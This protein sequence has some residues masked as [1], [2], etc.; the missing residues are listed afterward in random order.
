[1]TST[2]QKGKLHRLEP[3]VY[4]YTFGPDEPVLRIRSGDSI[5]AS[6]VDAGG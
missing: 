4:Q 5:T 2:P 1:M 6:T 3:R